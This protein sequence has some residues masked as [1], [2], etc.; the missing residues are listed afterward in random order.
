MNNDV[1]DDLGGAEPNPDNVD[2][3]R[4][5]VLLDAMR[6][7]PMYRRLLESDILYRRYT[8]DRRP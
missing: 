6:A 8:L 5:G 2:D 7:S 1:N 3:V 4:L